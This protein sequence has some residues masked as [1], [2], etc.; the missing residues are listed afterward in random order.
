MRILTLLAIALLCACA[1]LYPVQ[2]A[3][4]GPN[5]YLATQQSA[6]S[7]ID[8]RTAAIQRAGKFCQERG[9]VIHVTSQSQDRLKRPRVR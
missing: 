8:A 3:Q 4:T 2:I 9:K 6:S 1:P 5:T 7:W